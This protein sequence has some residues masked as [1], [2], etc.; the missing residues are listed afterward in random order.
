MGKKKWAERRP[1]EDYH[2][3]LNPDGT[4]AGKLPRVSRAELLRWYE[5]F[6]Q[7]RT[8]EDLT[9]KLQRRGVLS[10]TASSRGE[11]AVGL[12]VAAALKPGDWCFPSY[13][14]LSAHLYWRAP[15][16]RAMAGLMGNAPEHVREHLPMDPDSAP[17]VTFVPYAVFLGANV[18]NAVGCALAD[19]LAG[20]R[21]VTVAFVGE[22]TTSE[23]DF[24][25]GLNFAG[26]LETPCVIVVQNN[27]WCI[28]V[29]S[30]RQTAAETF[31]QKAVA[32]G[33]PHERVD[34]NDLFAVYDAAKRA[35]DRARRGRGATL[36]EAVSY[37]ILDHNTS[38]SSEVYRTE[39]EADYW[40]TLD[41]LDRFERHLFS[42][43]I[44]D[45]QQRETIWADAETALREQIDRGRGVPPTPPETMFL[46]HLHGDAGWSVR[47]QQAELA[48]EL[49]GRNPFTDF[50]GEGLS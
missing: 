37:R 10:V 35:T 36:I 19:K 11:E 20:R 34:G 27:Q 38:D 17:A 30:A 44:L 16:D 9:L 39:D 33:L 14:Q 40:R 28:S 45:Q 7:T 18:P 2:R 1:A 8:F 48:A 50:T 5:V 31:A 12:G 26:V 46:S 22:G 49:A 15:L 23:G 47:H 43:G 29:P 42:K 24:H 6:A 25:D 41:P 13:R 3:L 21:Q 32:Y 4:P